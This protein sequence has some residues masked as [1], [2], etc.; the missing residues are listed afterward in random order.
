VHKN[1]GL[2]VI[3]GPSKQDIQTI[4]PN[5]E[6]LSHKV[7]SSHDIYVHHGP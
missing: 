6:R 1:A 4:Q 5:P 3:S 2:A 7:R